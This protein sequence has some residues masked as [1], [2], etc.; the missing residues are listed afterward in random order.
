MTKG[1]DKDGRSWE[2]HMKDLSADTLI[3]QPAPNISS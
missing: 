2:S 3:H 1:F